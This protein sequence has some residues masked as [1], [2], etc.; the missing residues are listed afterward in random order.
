ML[1]PA[2]RELADA[3]V[4]MAASWIRRPGYDR[5]YD[6]LNLTVAAMAADKRPRRILPIRRVAR[7]LHRRA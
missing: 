3:G 2:I 1:G 4:S 6:A 7:P 5:V